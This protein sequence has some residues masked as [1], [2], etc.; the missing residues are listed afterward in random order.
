MTIMTGV[1]RLGRDAEVRY[2][3][4]GDAISTLSLAYNYGKK[5]IGGNKPTQWVDAGLWGERAIKLQEYLKKGTAIDVI[6][7]DVHLQ[8]F[9]R[10]D[11]TKGSKLVG[12][13]LKLDFV[14]QKAD[15]GAPRPQRAAPPPAPGSAPPF[16]RPAPQTGGSGF[17]DMDD[18][19]P[20]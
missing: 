9:D 8:E 6:L 15:D 7:E 3:P 10:R 18:D 2:T 19:I 14:G 16:Q 20:F 1:F 5:D 4:A 12:R 17:D 11:G 13:V